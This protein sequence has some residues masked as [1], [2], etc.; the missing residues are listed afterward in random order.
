M[1]IPLDFY[2]KLPFDEAYE[3]TKL[4][5]NI[6]FSR[7]LM[8]LIPRIK[9]YQTFGG[10]RNLASSNKLQLDTFE[11]YSGF[12]DI[13]ALRPHIFFN[14]IDFFQKELIQGSDVSLYVH[15]MSSI[16]QRRYS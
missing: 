13:W 1:S 7:K 8:S 3:G 15:G 4:Y 9:K 5:R 14:N 2:A 10:M 16:E 12:V 6:E 11:K